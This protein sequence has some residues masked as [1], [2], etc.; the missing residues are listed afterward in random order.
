MRS[1]LLLR[2]YFPTEGRPDLKTIGVLLVSVFSMI[3]LYYFGHHSSY[4]YIAFLFDAIECG[5]TIENAFSNNPY[6]QL[7]QLV[8]WVLVCFVAY[9]LMPVFYIC[10]VL[11]EK[12]RDYRLKTRGISNS[13]KIDVLL[14]AIVL[15]FII[16]AS[17][18]KSFQQTYPFFLPGSGEPL[19]SALWYWELFYALQFFRSNFFSEAL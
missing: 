19:F 15:P 13:W 3:V 17:F 1:Y 18:E 16:W 10:L 2:R 4:R 6:R 12:L 7:Y 9:F 14:F 5:D 8:W 11:K